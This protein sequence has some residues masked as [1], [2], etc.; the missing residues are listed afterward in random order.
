MEYLFDKRVLILDQDDVTCGRSVQPFCPCPWEPVSRY[1]KT[2]LSYRDL[3]INGIEAIERAEI[4]VYASL[5]KDKLNYVIE[6]AR[7]LHDQKLSF[8]LLE[9]LID[10]CTKELNITAASPK[11]RT[12][13]DLF[14][15]W[16]RASQF[17]SKHDFSYV[18]PNSSVINPNGV[19]YMGREMEERDIP[20][21]MLIG[22]MLQFIKTRE[23]YQGQRITFLVDS[24]IES[25]PTL[26]DLINRYIT[27]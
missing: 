9:D 11:K 1:V 26:E 24:T 12:G 3:Q 6:K 15:E 25:Y 18:D 5:Y 16:M 14:W 4:V 17:L 22:Y 23:T 19:I 20:K 13:M 27:E 8:R 10:F 21:I 7:G 2:R